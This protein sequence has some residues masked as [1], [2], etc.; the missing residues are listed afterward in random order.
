MFKSI[1]N[2]LNR[3]ICASM[4]GCMYIQ[5]YT[6]ALIKDKTLRAKPIMNRGQLWFT[7]AK[8]HNCYKEVD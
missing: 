8:K 2:K 4:Q 5:L 7:D 1:S 3:N 6:V